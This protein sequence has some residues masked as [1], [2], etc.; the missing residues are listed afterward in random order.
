MFINKKEKRNNNKNN[1]KNKNKNKNKD[2]SGDNSNYIY[3]SKIF[4]L[5]ILNLRKKR[6][7]KL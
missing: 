7:L 4:A 6:F 2:N 5:L 1:N 3:K